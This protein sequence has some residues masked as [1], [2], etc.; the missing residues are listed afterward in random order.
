MSQVVAVTS[1]KGV[2]A[3]FLDWSILYLAGLDHHYLYRQKCMVPIPHD[4]LSSEGGVHNAHRHDKNHPSGLAQT[5]QML[6]DLQANGAKIQT[7]YPFPLHLDHCYQQLNLDI[8]HLRSNDTDR[9]RALAVIMDDYQRLLCACLD[10]ASAL[11]YIDADPAP[12]GYYWN[13]RTLER[14]LLSNHRPDDADDLR[15]ERDDFYF[16]HSKTRWASMGL[17]DVWDRRERMALDC[18][19]FDRSWFPKIGVE[20]PYLHINCQDLWNLAPEILRLCF[21]YLEQS[22]HEPRWNSW[23]QIAQSWQTKQHQS[24]CFFHSLDHI[25]DATLNDWY[26]PLPKFELWQESIIQHCLIYKHGY[27]LKTW[28]LYQFPDNTQ[29]LHRLL[30]PNIHDVPRIY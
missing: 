15:N 21:D 1:H 3:T 11:I 20:R 26:Y 13:I 4:P 10:Q 27:N 17:M 22:I 9:S 29:K 24:L 19:P 7:F 6:P 30:E 5:L 16:A 18:R 14:R 23:L 12:A 2:G 8:E 25:I 28:Q